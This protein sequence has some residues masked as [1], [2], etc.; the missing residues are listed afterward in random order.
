MKA[1][2]A[3]GWIGNNSGTELTPVPGRDTVQVDGIE[4]P[5]D[6]SH[7][8]ACPARP[9]GYVCGNGFSLFGGRSVEILLDRWL[10]AG[11]P[12]DQRGRVVLVHFV[13]REVWRKV[14]WD[15]FGSPCSGW[16]PE[17]EVVDTEPAQAQCP[18]GHKWPL[19]DG[20]NCP[21]CLCHVGLPKPEGFGMVP[22][23]LMGEH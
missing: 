7:D 6:R 12:L 11:R 3:T 18:N 4:Y 20:M 22:H 19:D 14:Y 1:I 13:R 15:S 10:A 8:A 23:R 21:T 9:D 5:I 17:P 2:I 16:K